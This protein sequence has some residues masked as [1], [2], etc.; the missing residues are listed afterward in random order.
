MSRVCVPP[1]PSPPLKLCG[2][3][4]PN[5]RSLM[6]LVVGRG[7]RAWGARG[8]PP[9]AGG[10]HLHEFGRLPLDTPPPLPPPGASG[11]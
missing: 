1:S 3:L 7:V 8:E 10:C 5:C 2:E 4:V 11:E 6:A 9:M